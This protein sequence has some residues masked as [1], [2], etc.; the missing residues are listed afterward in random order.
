MGDKPKVYLAGVGLLVLAA[1]MISISQSFQKRR[2]AKHLDEVFEETFND[3]LS[4]KDRQDMAELWKSVKP[5]VRA[6]LEDDRLNDLP[7]LPLT[8]QRA[9]RRLRAVKEAGLPRLWDSSPP[10]ALPDQGKTTES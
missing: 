8:W 4:L 7:W 5:H 1:L 6:V 3:V 2:L 10:A 9:Y